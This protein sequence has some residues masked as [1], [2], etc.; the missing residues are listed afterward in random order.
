MARIKS[1]NRLDPNRPHGHP[2][3]VDCEYAVIEVDGKPLLQLTTR[4]SAD[5]SDPGTVSQTLQLDRNAATKLAKIIN[6]A[7]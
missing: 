2:T 3:E 4:G 1:F 5:R 6:Q 7:F